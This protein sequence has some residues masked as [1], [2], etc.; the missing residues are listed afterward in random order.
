MSNFDVVIGN[1]YGDEG[2]GLI[3]D[4]LSTPDS[5]VVRFNGGAQAGH[6]VLNSAGTRH[7][8]HHFGSGTFQR[9]PTFLSRFFACDPIL[10]EREREQLLVL[11]INPRVYVDPMSPI[12]TPYDV[13]L[14]QLTEKVRGHVR[15]GSC[16]CGFGE[17][18]RRQE[19]RPE[20]LFVADLD[21]PILLEKLLAIERATKNEVQQRG[22]VTGSGWGTL[23]E[24]FLTC[25]KL[26]L[27]AANAF[28]RHVT[29]ISF[30]ELQTNMPRHLVFEGAQGLLLDREIGMFPHVTRSKTGLA[31]VA[32]LLGSR[33]AEA[34]VYFIS[35]CYMTR[36]GEGPLQ[37][38]EPLPDWVVDP[39]NVQNDWQGALRYAVYDNE[40]LAWARRRALAEVPRLE[41]RHEVVTTCLDQITERDRRVI[42]D[43]S[44]FVSYGPTRDAVRAA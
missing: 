21:S 2:K 11:T 43:R 42:H 25:R 36:H 44:D 19:E 27:S 3:T 32:T 12:V 34:H 35:R 15:H 7:V 9:A 22:L 13:L 29:L 40:L 31:N 30:E 39:T 38:E 1:G 16:G 26:F 23:N 33:F 18:M 41:G 4:W 10:F 24:D 20:R 28:I 5:I 17:A 37:R 14:N 6:T 8:F